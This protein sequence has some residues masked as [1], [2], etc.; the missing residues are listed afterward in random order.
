M[1]CPGA[2][3]FQ[4]GRSLAPRDGL[5]LSMTER[6]DAKMQTDRNEIMTLAS[7]AWVKGISAG[8][9]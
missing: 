6:A 3:G 2:T 7:I 8:V 4:D 5:V 1:A 9:L